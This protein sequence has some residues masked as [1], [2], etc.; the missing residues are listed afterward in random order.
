MATKD[1]NIWILIVFILSGLVIGGLLGE[2]AKQVDFLWWLGYG[3]SFGLNSPISL[4]LSIVTI[5]F[6]LMFKVN[7]A[8]IIGMAI[9]IF[10]YKKI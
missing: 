6:G 1:K 4:D 7:I 10:I 3:E 2:L 9:A 5:T 8:S